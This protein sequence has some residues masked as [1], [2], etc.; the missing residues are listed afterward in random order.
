GL[1][2]HAEEVPRERWIRA[3]GFATGVATGTEFELLR[4]LRSYQSSLR[5]YKPGRDNM[6]LQN[7]WGDRGQDTKLG[8][9]FSLAELEAGSKL[10]ITHFQLD[11]GWQTG[12]SSNSAYG[13]S[14]DG[15]WDR[16]GYWQVN[17]EKYPNDL[18]PVIEKARELGIEL[19]LW[20]NPAKDNSYANWE[21]DAAQLIELHR[22]YGIR[23]FKI[24]GVLITDKTADRNLRA[25][26]DKVMEATHGE[27]V[28]NL[29]VTAG[30]RF[31]YHY[32][33]EYGNKFLENR[34]TDWGN[35]Y[36]HWTLRNLWQLSRYVPPSSLQIEFLNKWRN[37]DRYPADDPL[38]PANIPFEYC[39]AVTMMAQPLAWFEGSNLPEEAFRLGPVIR[40]YRK[41]QVAIHQGCILPIGEEPSGTSWT[42]F[43][44][45]TTESEGYI[46]IY[47]EYNDLP[48]ARFTLWGLHDRALM[49]EP[50]VGAGQQT[51]V[52]TDGEGNATFS[53][54]DRFTYALYRYRC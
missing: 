3:Y 51:Q 33:Y 54:P 1:G 17:K 19:C 12:R 43:Q 29:D 15:I 4:A 39:F 52:R 47:R 38:A 50:I 11:D 5:V 9:A 21:K 27:A 6:I 8:E 32:F 34:Y 37:P 44:S 25:M 36:P 46:I 49:L 16:D 35:Y 14:L 42:G 7:T 26:L 13:G 40:E 20:Y 45:I 24:D 31:G 10:G 53:L 41:H 2:L 23:T 28:F 30:K 22:K 48:T 18:T